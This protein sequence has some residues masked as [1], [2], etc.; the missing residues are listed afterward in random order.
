MHTSETP[1]RCVR[2]GWSGALARATAAIL[3]FEFISGLAITFGPF[4]PAVEW[5]LLLHTGVGVLTLAPLA[6]Y[7]VRHWKGRSAAERPKT[8]IAPAPP[9]VLDS[10][11]SGCACSNQLSCHLA[12]S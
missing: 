6:W 4:Y 7:F 2:T 8:P 11:H 3:L 12:Y 1:V 5:G 9:G 10:L